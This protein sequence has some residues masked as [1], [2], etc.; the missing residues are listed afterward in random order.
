[1]IEDSIYKIIG[2][3]EYELNHYSSLPEGENKLLWK[4]KKKFILR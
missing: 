4:V 3:E 1:M 2:T